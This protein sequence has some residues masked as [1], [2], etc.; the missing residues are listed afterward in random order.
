MLEEAIDMV[1][2][3]FCVFLFVLGGKSC[4]DN[5]LKAERM[6]RKLEDKKNNVNNTR[7][8]LESIQAFKELHDFNSIKKL[9]TKM[10]QN[11]FVFEVLVQD[12][13]YTDEPFFIKANHPVIGAVG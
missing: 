12:K 11:S 10:Y 1:G 4:S 7:E 13:L 2:L 9:K 5:Q 3:G 8:L 6:V